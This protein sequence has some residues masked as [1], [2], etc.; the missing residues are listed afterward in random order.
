MNLEAGGLE[1]R[2][3][4]IERPQIRRCDGGAAQQRAGEGNGIGGHGS[5]VMG[6]GLAADRDGVNDDQ[7]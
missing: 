5:A 6:S 4:N 1:R 7:N 2:S 3:D